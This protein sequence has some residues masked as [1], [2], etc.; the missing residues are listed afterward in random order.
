MNVAARLPAVP[1][2]ALGELETTVRKEEKASAEARLCTTDLVRECIMLKGYC[3][4]LS[5]EE[6]ASRKG[7]TKEL[8]SGSVHIER[9]LL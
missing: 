6:M 7:T 1:A 9:R 5:V 8:L 4:A 3:W 2:L